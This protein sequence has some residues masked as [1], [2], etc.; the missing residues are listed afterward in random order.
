MIPLN[1]HLASLQPY[2]PGKPIEEVKRELGLDR[3]VKLASNENPLGP[4]PRAIEALRASAPE[5]HL[6][7]EGHAHELR[8][9][10]SEHLGVAPERLIFGNG[11]DEILMLVALTFLRPGTNLVMSRHGFIRP[12]QH[13]TLVGAET[14]VIDVIPRNFE[15]DVEAMA[16]AIDDSTRAVYLANPNNPTGDLV[17]HERI[18]GL[19]EHVPSDCLF[20][21]DAAYHEYCAERE[22]YRDPLE[23]L[24]EFPNML[25]LRTFSKAYGLAGLRCGYAVGHPDVIREIERVRPPFNVTRSAQIGALA[26]L[27]DQGHVARGLEVNRAGMA[28]IERGLAPLDVTVIPSAGN[29]LLIDVHRPCGPVFEALLRRGVIVR[30]MAGYELPSC[31]RVSIGTEEENALFLGALEETLSEAKS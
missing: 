7:P 13:A 14:K 31:V 12:L 4:S 22:E 18:R 27:G 2:P 19:L 10:I 9:A 8:H 28:Q 25:V 3:V 11:S 23:W 15:Q 24:D 1:P 16:F 29:F 5:L 20:L 17:N 21:C 26:A 30:P 6:Y